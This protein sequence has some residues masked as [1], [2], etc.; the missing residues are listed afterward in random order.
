MREKLKDEGILKEQGT[1]LEFTEDYLFKSPS[2]AAAVILAR[3]ANGWTEWKT[4][5][6]KTI[7]ETIRQTN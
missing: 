4:K 1:V 7:D 6:K 2:A 3:R 5:D